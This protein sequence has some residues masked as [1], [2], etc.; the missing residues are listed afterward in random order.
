MKAGPPEKS[1]VIR[2]ENGE[3]QIIE[4][5]KLNRVKRAKTGEIFIEGIEAVKQAVSA[6]IMLTRIVYSEKTVLSDWAR[7]LIAAS[8]G[9]KIIQTTDALY[10]KLCDRPEPSEII[11]TA[12]MRCLKLGDL[13]LPEKPFIV[14]F[15]RPGDTGNLGSVIRS[16]NAF[17]VDALL[18]LGH[19][20]DVYDPKTI[21]ASLGGVFHTRIVQ[22]ES[23][24]ELEG[25]VEAEKARCGMKIAGTDSK[26]ALPLKNET[27]QRPVLLVLG[28]EAKGISVA[29]KNI[30]DGIV[31]IPL[32][33]QVNSLNVAAAAGIFMWEI[34]RNSPDR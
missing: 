34:Y 25:F 15:D 6:K 33:G 22:V 10:R 19:G 17:A 28:N 16:A 13:R 29:L 7:G 5:L 26:G 21:R 30:C 24:R 1:A 3:F 11:A 2:A 27:L 12:K 23:M 18:I 9:A 8:S 20:A 4:A 32:S 14:L 31:S